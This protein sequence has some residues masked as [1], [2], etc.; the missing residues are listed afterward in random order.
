MGHVCPKFYFM[1]FVW[2][3]VKVGFGLSLKDF[4]AN[5][6]F[7]VAVEFGQKDGGSILA[8]NGCG[9]HV[10]SVVES[11]KPTGGEIKGVVIVL[12][13]NRVDVVYSAQ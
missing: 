9:L 1:G 11:M 4:G 10:E 6:Y 12:G 5:R 8:K 3:I 2:G 7:I 13:R